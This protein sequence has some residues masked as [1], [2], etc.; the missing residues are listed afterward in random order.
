[1]LAIFGMYLLLVS[2]DL[3]FWFLAIELQSFCFYS[4]LHIEP[5]DLFFKRSRVK[6]LYFW[7]FSKFFIF[8]WYSLI[9]LIFGTLN[10]D[11][12]TALTFFTLPDNLV[13]T[14]YI[15]LLL[16]FFSLFFKLGIAPFHS[17]YHKFI[18]F[19]QL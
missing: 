12:I 8:I 3:F 16:I 2:H 14:L 13:Y 5:I 15:A 11:A 19:L 4:L 7:F 17:G 1:M 10:L 6:V 18:L 9:Y